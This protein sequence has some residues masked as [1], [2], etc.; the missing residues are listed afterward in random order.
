MGPQDYYGNPANG[1]GPRK[2]HGKGE[3][4]EIDKSEVTNP[5]AYNKKKAETAQWE[6]DRKAEETAKRRKQEAEWREE[7][8]ARKRRENQLLVAGSGVGFVG[9]V[10]VVAFVL[11]RL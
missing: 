9:M 7:A 6:K 2:A 8:R 3:P 1:V 10:V 4:G 11:T 5:A